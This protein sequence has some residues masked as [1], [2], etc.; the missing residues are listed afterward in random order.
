MNRSRLTPPL[1][2]PALLLAAASASA[3]D[4]TLY[5]VLD[6]GLKYTHS[7]VDTFE[8]DG[9]GTDSFEMASGILSGSRFGLRGT[10]EIS[11]GLR[12]GFNLENGFDSDDGGLKYRGRLF[13]REAVLTLSGG[14][15]TFLFGRMGAIGSSV[16][17]CDV[18]YGLAD[19]FGGGEEFVWGMAASTRYDNM[20]A[21]QSPQFSG[22][23][24]TMQYSFKQDD[25]AEASDHVEGRST[26]DRYAS[27]AITGSWGPANF[28]LAWERFMPSTLGRRDTPGMDDGDIVYAGGNC[29]LGDVRLF[30]LGQW[31]SGMRSLDFTG[32]DQ[33][34]ADDSA[35]LRSSSHGIEGAGLHLGA[36][37]PLGPGE[38]TLGLYGTEGSVEKSSAGDI[39]FIYVGGAVRFTYPLSKRTQFYAGAGLARSTLERYDASQSRD[40]TVTTGGAYLGINHRF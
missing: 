7:R 11:P 16:G 20:L 12:I 13:G 3:A 29:G 1:A 8:R 35:L 14:F 31:F 9:D 6:T 24:I 36:L 4:V 32:L 19:S 33:V 2:L 10:E 21:W 37:V 40:A 28:V 34:L 38:L 17:S 25:A 26:A 30:V 5:G 22:V 23:Q 15:G 18:I 39:D 27:G